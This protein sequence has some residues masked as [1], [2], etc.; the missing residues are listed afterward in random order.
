M[1]QAA[2]NPGKR[3]A[4]SVK[5]ARSTFSAARRP[6]L[7]RASLEEF[8][9]GDTLSP[10]TLPPTPLVTGDTLELLLDPGAEEIFL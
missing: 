7:Y 4:I 9:N 1:S 6:C 10:N 5:R 2:T 3:G 8:D